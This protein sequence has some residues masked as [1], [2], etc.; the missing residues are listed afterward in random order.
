MFANGLGLYVISVPPTGV[1]GRS[2]E[3]Y[4]LLSVYSILWRSLN[5][6]NSN[7]LGIHEFFSGKV[8]I[9]GRNQ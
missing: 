5:R 2:N 6:K 9:G 8:M 7:L 4:D 3:R 1:R